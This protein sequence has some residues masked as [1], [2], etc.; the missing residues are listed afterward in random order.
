MCV[1][2]EKELSQIKSITGKNKQLTKY[3]NK[4]MKPLRI[5]LQGAEVE[6]SPP[7]QKF[8]LPPPQKMTQNDMNCH[9]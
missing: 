7:L 2:N 6:L 8:S 9:F 3:N 4:P 1:F 5:Y